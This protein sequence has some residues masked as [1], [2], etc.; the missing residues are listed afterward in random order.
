VLK[1]IGLSN[2]QANSS[3]R[4]SFNERTKIDEIDEIVKVTESAIN[5]FGGRE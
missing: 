2:D 5:I 3:V 1:A 4:F